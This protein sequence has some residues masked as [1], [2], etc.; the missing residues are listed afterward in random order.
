M[1]GDSYEAVGYRV[2][3]YGVGFGPFRTGRGEGV[4]FRV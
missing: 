4:G 3:I 1:Y 2:K